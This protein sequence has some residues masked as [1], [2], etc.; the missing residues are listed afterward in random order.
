M[1]LYV[2]L[3]PFRSPRHV[4]IIVIVIVVP[5]A[6]SSDKRQNSAAVKTLLPCIAEQD[7]MTDSRSQQEVHPGYKVEKL[8]PKD[9]RL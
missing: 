9:W 4:V 5:V 8:L 7:D 6:V 1:R 2:Y 3:E